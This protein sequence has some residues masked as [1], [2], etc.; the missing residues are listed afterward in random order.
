MTRAYPQ[1]LRTS[2]S[3]AVS[4]VSIF[5][6]VISFVIG[7]YDLLKMIRP[8]FTLS[9][10]LREKYKTNES[11]TEFG[12]FKKNFPEERITYER[13]ANYEK[14]LRME[15]QNARQR[16][17]KVGF[18]LLIVVIINGVFVFSSPRKRE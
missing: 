1:N 10:A 2:Y 14:L 9:S 6:V 18:A 4:F 15:R 13:L 17:V 3:L 11:Y 16:L 8:E 12:T 5:V 7:G